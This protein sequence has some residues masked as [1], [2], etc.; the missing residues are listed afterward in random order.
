MSHSTRSPIYFFIAV[1]FSSALPATAAKIANFKKGPGIVSA[2]DLASNHLRYAKHEGYIERWM[3]RVERRDK[4]WM[5][6]SYV[7]A[8]L[9]PGDGHALVDIMRFAPEMGKPNTP[10]TFTRR[11]KRHKKGSWRAST[12][13]LNVKIGKSW[14][15][16]TRTGLK[17][18]IKAWDY[19]VEF[20]LKHT[21][22]PWKPGNGTL[23]FPGH[24]DLAFQHM[25]TRS[26]IWG[27][28]RRLN[29][30]WHKFR[31]IATA[32]H[33]VTNVMPHK[34]AN[35][36]L[37]FEGTSGPYS[38]HYLE[39]FT[40]SKWNKQ[41]FGW[42]VVT[43]GATVVTSS[44]A[45]HSSPLQFRRDKIE[46][47]HRVPRRYRVIAMTRDGPIQL[48]VST[49]GSI[50]REDLLAPLPALFRAVL[51]MF[52]QPVNFYDRT[53]FWLRL[54]GRTAPI[55]GRGLSLYSPMRTN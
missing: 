33:G 45:A 11:P 49:R 53:R 19:Q 23:T 6:L 20:E 3:I 48:T 13:V 24:G 21:A 22:P 47:H 44:L 55:K 15:K 8:N 31:G 27:R 17:G 29:G 52:V 5:Q 42:I 50:H 7:L 28:E 12:T 16:S 46:P 34:L 26:R 40:P 1:L 37:R 51:K 32:E 10:R 39:L 38:V 25:A 30:K 2:G 54:P 35:R 36:W 14:L 18:Y 41:R 4:G 9:G 43:K